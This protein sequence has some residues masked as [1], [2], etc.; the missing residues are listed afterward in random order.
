MWSNN[1]MKSEKISVMLVDDHAV[2]R[3]GYR[4]LLSQ[5]DHIEVVQEAERGEEAC[6]YYAE[7]RPDVIV[8]DLSLPG[9]GGLAAI[10]RICGRDPQAKVL[11]FSMHDEP[12]Y[13]LRAIEAGA[14]GYITKSCAPDTLVEAVGRIAAGDNYIEPEIAQRLAMQTLSG[15]DATLLNSLSAREFDVFCLLARGYTTREVADELSLGYKT[16]A[17]YATLIK[18]KLNVNTSAEMARLA[19]QHGIFKN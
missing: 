18:N 10:R 1:S 12:L 13:V 6:Q 17:N 5:S 3:A 4:L 8:M 15:T 14:K 19:F 9:I 2:V 16:V 11:A 7:V